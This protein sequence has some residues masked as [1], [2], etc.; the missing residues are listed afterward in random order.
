LREGEEKPGEGDCHGPGEGEGKEPVGRPEQGR[1]GEQDR[2]NEIAAVDVRVP[3]ERVDPEVEVEVVRGLELVVP[4]DV[5]LGEL[6]D[7]DQGQDQSLGEQNQESEPE[8]AAVPGRL[9]EQ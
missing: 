6:P 8:Q 7:P 1:R 9:R 4:E 2:E 5:L 3:E